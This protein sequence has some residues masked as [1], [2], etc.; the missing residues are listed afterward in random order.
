MEKKKVDCVIIGGGPGGY[1]AAI[2][3]AQGGKKVLLVEAKELGGTCLN[4]GCI[5]TKSYLSDTELYHLICNS[6]QKGI[7]VENVRYDWKVMKNKKDGVVKKL[8]TSLTGVL[9]SYGIEIVKGYA[10]FI[11][12]KSVQIRS[13][14]IISEVEA[15]FFIIASGSEP[16]EIGSFPFDGVF[17]HSS[18]TILDIEKVPPSLLIVGGGAIG[19]EFASIFRALG[20]EV[21]I[22]EALDRILPFE[23]KNVSKS[24]TKAFQDQ[25]IQVKT[26]VSVKSIKKEKGGICAEISD[27]TVINAS[28][29]L[30]SIGRSLN[31]SKE[32]GLDK[33]GVLVEKGAIVVDDRMRTNVSHIW[34][35]GDV[36][37]K[38]LYAHAATHQGIVASENILGHESYMQYDAIP[39]VVF[40]NPQIGS[41]GL[42]FDA[43]KSKGL[44]V[45]LSSYPMQGLGKA[46]A[47][48]KEYGFAQV[49]VEQKTGRIVGAQVVGADAETLIAEMTI[50]IANELT[51][52][53]ISETIHA[54]PTFSEIWMETSF[55]AVK[56]PLHFPK[57]GM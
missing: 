19:G 40:T 48:Q 34:A 33:A 18:T 39:G 11:N 5:P 38:A 37:G 43:A 27:G 20:T 16:K 44:D 29:A 55:M 31:T 2:R 53:C 1:P 47:S 30:V 15:D 36:V 4:R 13:E 17:I 3:L 7:S 49:V 42:S 41:V 56:K 52:E 14:G 26:S 6:V 12:Q 57:Q 51:I 24:L 21:T 35:V 45:V 50:A 23:C 10:S 54:H 8:R 32:L 22:V 25:G 46:Q 28:C 9:K